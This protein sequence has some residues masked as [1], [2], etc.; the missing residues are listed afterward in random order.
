MG[1]FGNSGLGQAIG[2]IAGGLLGGVGSIVSSGMSGANAAAINQANYEH[3]KEFAQNGIRWKVADAK[4]AGLHPLA[5]LG[6][7]TSGYTPSAVV[8]DSPDFSFLRDIGQ[9][10]G[11][12]ID[13]KSTAAERAANKAKI[14]QGTNLE[15]EG[16]SLDNEYKRALIKGETQDQALK[17]ANAAVRA[18]WSQ[19]LPPAMPS[20]ARDG[21]V[22]SGQGDATS[23]AGVEVKPAEIVVN[24][25]QTRF[26]E[27]GSHPDTRWLRTAT[28]G[29]Q[30][31]RSDAAQNALEDD[32][33][34]SARYETRNGLGNFSNDE[35]FAPPRAYLPNG[36][37]D[38][39]S[40]F[41]D[42]VNGEWY[43]V[44]PGDILRNRPKFLP[45]KWRR[46]QGVK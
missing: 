45:D 30:P 22:M 20:L 8:G 11:R 34:G 3:Q 46:F 7:Q 26:A 44:K 43:A 39:H 31:V 2:G 29:Y 4:A 6:A 42:F 16:K 40:W 38:G 41:Y 5:A 10:V 36:G 24:D 17:L 33:I 14:D 37:R 18:S 21:S 35:R 12:A 32:V 1:L 28:G 15:L 23:P 13:A 27:A 25:P 19:Q 9:D